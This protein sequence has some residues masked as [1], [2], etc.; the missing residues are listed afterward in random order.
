MDQAAH[1]IQGRDARH[2][3]ADNRRVVR[4]FIAT[5]RWRRKLKMFPIGEKKYASD[6]S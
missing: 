2:T 6:Q 5:S 4:W 3:L 1:A